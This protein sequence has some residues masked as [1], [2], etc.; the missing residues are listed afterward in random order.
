MRVDTVVTITTRIVRART[1]RNIKTFTRTASVLVVLQFRELIFFFSFGLTAYDLREP[2]YHT[3]FFLVLSPRRSL[4]LY[5]TRSDQFDR[6]VTVRTLINRFFF[7]LQTVFYCATKS[8]RSHAPIRTRV[9]LSTV[10]EYRTTNAYICESTF[11]TM[12]SIKS[13]LKNRRERFI[14]EIVRIDGSNNNEQMAYEK[15]SQSSH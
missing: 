14:I 7:Q 9:I 2:P 12:N 15:Q 3:A 10:G 8:L 11:S 6:P 4:W 13:N 1:K 5:G